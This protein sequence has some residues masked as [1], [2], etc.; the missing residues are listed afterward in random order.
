MKKAGK[1]EEKPETYDSLVRRIMTCQAYSFINVLL[2]RREAYIC[3]C[4]YIFFPQ[5]LFL[6]AWTLVSFDTLIY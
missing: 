2:L 1:I 3:V 5:F 4:V 6:L